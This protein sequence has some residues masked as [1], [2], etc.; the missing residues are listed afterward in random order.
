MGRDRC[1]EAINFQLT[2][3]M[4]TQCPTGWAQADG[5][6]YTDL[7]TLGGSDALESQA[8]QS[9]EPLEIPM[10]RSRHSGKEC[11]RLIILKRYHR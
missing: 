5:K 6:S 8:M 4:T 3:T 11:L 10:Q 2:S 9:I 1:L 7:M